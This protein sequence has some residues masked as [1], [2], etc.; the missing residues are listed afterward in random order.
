M[1]SICPQSGVFWMVAA[2]ENESDE[3]L[4]DATA[5]SINTVYS[6]CRVLGDGIASLP[7]RIYKQTPTGKQEDIDAPL[8]HL[9]QFEPNEETS[10]YSFFETLVL[11]LML[12][13]NGY[14]EIQRNAAGD[15][16][17]LWNLDP[18]KTEPV[19]LGSL[20]DHQFADHYFRWNQSPEVHCDHGRFQDRGLRANLERNA[21]SQ[22]N[23]QPRDVDESW[24]CFSIQVGQR[25]RPRWGAH[26]GK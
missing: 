24:I 22:H 6:C 5:L 25:I 21:G 12:R 8:S 26:L 19:R 4:N 1:A 2:V 17:A 13:G 3:P 11:H 20:D 23:G 15:P 7:C 10:A 18:R 14:A 9:L 16:V